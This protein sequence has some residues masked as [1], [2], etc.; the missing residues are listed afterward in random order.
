M[1]LRKDS[2]VSDVLVY[3][4]YEVL[5]NDHEEVWSYVRTLGEERL[6]VTLNF[7]EFES[8]T[9]IPEY[10]VEFNPHEMEAELLLCNYGADERA[11][12]V[13]AAA[14]DLRPWEARIYRL[15]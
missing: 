7:A 10:E 15:R 14:F 9:W 8:H 3:G 12:D 5:I 11:T 2:D 4:D 6:L 13:D 1:E